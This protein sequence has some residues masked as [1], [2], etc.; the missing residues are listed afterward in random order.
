MGP[1]HGV[2]RPGGQ[3]RATEG[4]VMRAEA[5]GLVVGRDQAASTGSRSCSYKYEGPWAAC[6]LLGTLAGTCHSLAGV[7]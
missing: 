7:N 1:S 5:I 3:F 4:S 6:G 2:G